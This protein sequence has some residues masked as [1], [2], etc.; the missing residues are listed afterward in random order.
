MPNKLQD[1]TV[2][3]LD[4]LTERDPQSAF[5]QIIAYQDQGHT[6]QDINQLR[7]LKAK[8]LCVMRQ[9]DTVEPL[10]EE[11]ISEAYTEKDY[12]ILVNC[13]IM[14]ARIYVNLNVK[15]R[16]IPC[17][18][19]AINYAIESEDKNLLIFAI[20]NY[21]SYL[22]S[23]HAY[24]S[25]IIEEARIVDLMKR[26]PPSKTSIDALLS[27]AAAR[28]DLGNYR[29]AITYLLKAMS[30]S[31]NIEAPKMKLII[32]NNL[33][34]IYINL[35]EYDKA[36]ELLLKGLQIAK[37][38]EDDYSIALISFTLG[39]LMIKMYKYPES[40]AYFDQSY[41]LTKQC[42]TITSSFMIDLYNNFSM[43]YHLMNKVELALEFMDKA[44][45]LA[46]EKHFTDDLV[47]IEVNKTNLLISLDRYE[48][49][50]DILQRA[51]KHYTKSKNYFQLLW[52]YRSLARLYTLQNNY[53]KSYNIYCK[54]DTI[55]DLYIRV[56]KNR[57]DEED[58]NSF[59]PHEID[60]DSMK[61]HQAN[62]ITSGSSYGFIGN[63]K[64]AQK[65]LS[66]AL[67]AAQHINTNVLIIG[68][69]GTGKEIIANIIHKNSVRRN[70]SFI[71]VNVS[72][73][74]ASL[75]ESELFG[76]I[77]GAFTGADTSNKGYFLQADKGTLFL[78]EITEMPYELQSKMLRVIESKKVTAVGSS[79][80]FAY[81]SRIISATNRDPRELVST[82]HFRLDLFHRLN[83][84]EIYIP[85]LRDRTDDI[86]PLL[87]YY[88]EYYSKELKKSKPYLD[89]SLLDVL[90]KYH[91]PG[92]VR[93]LKNIVERM[94]ILSKSMNWD[95]QLLCS[96][97]PFILSQNEDKY[98]KQTPEDELILQA[99]IKAKGK[100]KD[101]AVLLNMSEA[102]LH[103]RIVKYQLQQYTRK[104]N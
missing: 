67:L 53:K 34:S 64:A 87:Q 54:V 91:F 43:C 38:I 70:Y 103:R 48:E 5:Q 16:S 84:I 6:I 80:E 75:I 11:C 20:S 28:N 2:Q 22:R 17:L 55:T 29:K 1:Q 88:V 24:S 72:A 69:S 82:N 77:K 65:V 100:Q 32:V 8:A 83:T 79:K 40:I 51:I 90:T 78:D 102:T 76:H 46:K 47:Q 63:S 101:A 30:I 96:V 9:Y 66:S 97:N 89:I 92:N 33:S 61:P 52:V 12:P 104:G 60:F 58:T 37:D 42:P 39:N 31:E 3:Y 21:I 18:E 81:D 95:A 49:A 62:N 98:A 99:L 45:F 86:D 93:E 56:L 14:L 71:P 26:V 59:I 85:P 25:V 41:A 27:I 44:I 4:A 68:E 36:E 7:F 13:N 94:Y 73:L 10:V 23:I 74:S 57:K 35:K 15:S 50:K 19:T